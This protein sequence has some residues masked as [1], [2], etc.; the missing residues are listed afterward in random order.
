MYGI[1][2]ARQWSGTPVSV[3]WP[4]YPSVLSNLNKYKLLSLDV[5]SSQ[6]REFPIA[7]TIDIATDADHDKMLQDIVTSV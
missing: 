5:L 1:Q 3:S 4:T 6:L 2:R 7:L